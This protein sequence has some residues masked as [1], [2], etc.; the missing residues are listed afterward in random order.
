M[1]IAIVA[2]CPVPYVRG[3]AENLWRSLLDELDAQPG[4]QAELLKLP[5]REHTLRDLIDT[6]EDFARL[7]LSG[8]DAVI[9]TKYPAWMVDH[10]CHIVYLQ[11]RLRGLYDTYHFTRLPLEVPDPVPPVA[12]VLEHLRASAGRRDTLPE[13]FV[14]LRALLD[15]PAVDPA[16][17]AFPSPFARTVVHHLDGIGLHPSRIH[18]YA[19]ISETVRRREGYF[20]DGVDVRVVPHPSGLAIAPPSRLRRVLRPGDALFTASRLDGAKRVHL[21]IEAMGHVREDVELRIAGTGPE[22]ERLRALAAGDPRIAFLGYVDDARLAAEYAAARAVAFV[23]FEE[24]LGLVTLEAMS[25]AKP[26]ITVV[27]AGGATELVRDGVNGAVVE[28]TPAALAGA[29]D[30]LWGDRRR[31]IAQGRAARATAHGVRWDRVVQGLLA[32]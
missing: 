32:P 7:D 18:R 16:V 30:A 12:A 17:L 22:E 3:G 23:P 8:F 27:D 13:T 14:R 21:L 11:H 31:A 6:Y 20:P 10:P 15:D 9:S 19:A 24:D 1:N 29:I 4:V 5:S 25:A 26:V 2:P 28:P